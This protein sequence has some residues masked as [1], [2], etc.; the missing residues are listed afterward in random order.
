ML[1]LEWEWDH[2]LIPTHFGRMSV[3]E[4]T[5]TT[6][7]GLLRHV[8]C[9]LRNLAA[10]SNVRRSAS[11]KQR[12]ASYSRRVGNA[13]SM[14]EEGNSRSLFGICAC[15]HEEDCGSASCLCSS[16]QQGE[17]AEKRGEEQ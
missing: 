17:L 10:A 7:A 5:S 15:V 1:R 16:E 9:C 11:F 12:D 14:N 13:D 8:L 4:L 2:D 6:D 3:L